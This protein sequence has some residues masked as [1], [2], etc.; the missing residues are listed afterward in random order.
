MRNVLTYLPE[1]FQDRI[2]AVKRLV[3]FGSNFCSGDDHFSGYKYQKNDSGLYHAI[4]QT[5]KKFWLV[6]GE[7]RVREDERFETDGKPDVHRR[8]HVLHG[9]IDEARREA[10]FLD[11]PSVLAGSQMRLALA[12]RP[13]HH[14]L[15]RREDQRRRFR[16]PDSHYHRSEP[17]WIIFGISCMQSYPLQIKF[18]IKIDCC[19]YILNFR[20][21]TFLIYWGKSSWHFV[22]LISNFY[23]GQNWSKIRHFSIKLSNG[24]QLNVVRND[25]ELS[26]KSMYKH[27]G[28]T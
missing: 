26:R 22:V 23:C 19:N 7:L 18:A 9:E 24:N 12:T 20:Y 5:R 4:D 1:A 28:K 11:D 17:L 2:H 21:D 14:H 10:D 3:N 15:A 27:V 16:P 25:F 13:R 8:H 6:C